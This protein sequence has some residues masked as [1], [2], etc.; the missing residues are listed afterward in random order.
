MRDTDEPYLCIACNT[1]LNGVPAVVFHVN[2]GFHRVK[3]RYW[4]ILPT[5]FRIWEAEPLT[6]KAFRDDNE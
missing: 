6:K 1:V 2:K 5:V 3:G 4:W